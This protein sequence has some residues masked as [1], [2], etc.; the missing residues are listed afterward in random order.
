MFY[1]VNVL[2]KS[3]K[4]VNIKPIYKTEIILERIALPVL[5]TSQKVK[6]SQL[7]KR[8]IFYYLKILIKKELKFRLFNNKKI[9]LSY[10]KYHIK[11]TI[12]TNS[13][14]NQF[15]IVTLKVPK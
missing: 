4:L 10:K 7:S 2:L 1:P 8:S 14:K 6:T 9:Y 11:N 13:M 3:Q 12:L 15:D 5:Q